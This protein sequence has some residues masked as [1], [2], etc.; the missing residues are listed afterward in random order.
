MTLT[1]CTCG[2]LPVARELNNIEFWVRCGECSLESERKTGPT[3]ARNAWN[4]LIQ[5]REAARQTGYADVTRPMIAAGMLNRSFVDGETTPD[6][7]REVVA[8]YRAMRAAQATHN[9]A[10]DNG[11]VIDV[12]AQRALFEAANKHRP[13]MREDFERPDPEVHHRY[14][15]TET[16]AAWEGWE[17]CAANALKAV[18]PVAIAN[19]CDATELADALADPDQVH[20][21]I[22]FDDADRKPELVRGKKRALLR[23]KQISA[24][25]NA[26]LFVKLDSNSRDCLAP[27]DADL[28]LQARLDEELARFKFAGAAYDFD[29][30][31]IANPEQEI[32]ALRKECARLSQGWSEAADLVA[33]LQKKAGSTAQANA[34]RIAHLEQW[35]ESGKQ[36]GFKWNTYSFDMDIRIAAQ[37]DAHIAKLKLSPPA[38][39]VTISR[40]D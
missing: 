23:Y 1:V 38:L 18:A 6:G 5:A 19:K 36:R 29:T 26:H 14:Y 10:T 31:K 3:K 33:D 39:Q 11:P 22:V 35:R 24:S 25:W 28:R 21:L 12:D 9:P 30:T 37:I 20:Y 8:I 40:G 15:D 34:A 7:E 2:G 16:Q 13:L 4:E 27:N 32:A 17:S